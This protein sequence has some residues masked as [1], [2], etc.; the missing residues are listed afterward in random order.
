M[1]HTHEFEFAACRGGHATYMA[2]RG[3]FDLRSD[4]P[5]ICPVKCTSLS[6][7]LDCLICRSNDL[8]LSNMLSVSWTDNKSK[9]RTHRH[10]SLLLLLTQNQIKIRTLLQ[11]IR[12]SLKNADAIY[13]SSYWLIHCNFKFTAVE[14]FLDHKSQKHF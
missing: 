4:G 8:Y 5:D 13:I 10:L 9:L 14:Q 6:V 2:E 1:G 11:G 7:H 12:H 3:P